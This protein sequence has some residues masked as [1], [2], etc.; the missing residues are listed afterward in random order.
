M[1]LRLVSLL[2]VFAT[3]VAPLHAQLGPEGSTERLVQWSVVGGAVGW[4]AGALAVGGPLARWN[5][6]GSEALDD[7]LWTPGIVIGF[8]LGQ[9]LAIP[10]AVHVAN[11]RQG[12]LRRS[13]AASLAIGALGTLLLWTDDFDAVFET[14]R[15]QAVLLAVPVAQ[16]L[17]SIALERRGRRPR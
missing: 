9:A 16:I 1:T 3:A 2:M 17:T 5:P 13:L 11:G 4:T 15:R 7:G 14:R 6:L 10:L 12:D 8:E